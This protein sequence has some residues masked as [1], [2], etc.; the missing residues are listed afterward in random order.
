MYIK[1]VNVFLIP[2][3]VRITNPEVTTMDLKPYPQCKIVPIRMLEP[4][5]AE[6]FLDGLSCIPGIRRM[7]VQGPGYY[8]NPWTHEVSEEHQESRLPLHTD[9]KIANHDVKMYVLTGS[10]VVEAEYKPVLDKVGEY[11]SEFFEDLSFQILTG[12]FIKPILSTSNYVEGNPNT[13]NYL[14]GLSDHRDGI[15][16]YMIQVDDPSQCNT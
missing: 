2:L 16:P 1:G 12:T 7:L 3:Y 11:C 15:E 6:K 10:V 9:V 8:S 5:N 13:D 14:I 4:D